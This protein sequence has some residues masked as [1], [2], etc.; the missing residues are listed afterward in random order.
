[1]HETNEKFDLCNSSVYM[2]RGMGTLIRFLLTVDISYIVQ[3][4]VAYAICYFEFA[5]VIIFTRA[6]YRDQRRI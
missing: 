5:Y 3:I 4:S 6:Y 1:M 2:C